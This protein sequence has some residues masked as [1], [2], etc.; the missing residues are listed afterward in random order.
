[1]PGPK[2]SILLDSRVADARGSWVRVDNSTDDDELAEKI[3]AFESL[4][5]AAGTEAA[6]WLRED[7]RDNDGL[8]LTRVLVTDDRVEG[9]ISTTYGQVELTNGPMRRLTVPNRLR[10]RTVPAF[11]VCWVA[12]HVDGDIPGVQLM[13]TAVGLA[14]LAKRSG[15]L[16]AFAVDPHDEETSKMWRSDP[17]NF[18]LCR[19]QPD[20]DRPT[21][22]FI[23]I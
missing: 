21:R 14:R 19:E 6:R 1:M 8:S 20:S 13:L 12:R 17:Y 16:V 15:G 9:Y 5:N 10:R 22:L 2:R 11:V 7:A 18:Q 4:P 3:A 23:P